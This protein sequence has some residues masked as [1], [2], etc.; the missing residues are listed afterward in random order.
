MGTQRS[1]ATAMVLIGL[2][3][4]ATGVTAEEA[5]T[6]GD[7]TDAYQDGWGPALGDP[8]PPIAAEDQGGDVRDLASLS[9]EH[10]LVLI[11]SRSA[12]W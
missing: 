11:V 4:A 12:V 8:I 6:D 2:L 3:A 10:G 7:S 1:T 9:G 5:S